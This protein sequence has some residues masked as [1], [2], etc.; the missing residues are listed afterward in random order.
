MDKNDLVDFLKLLAIL[1]SDEYKDDR[2]IA[3]KAMIEI[4]ENNP[5][6]IRDLDGNV[7]K[8]EDRTT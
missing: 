4:L 8:K 1:L 7:I 5:I 2:E 6:V 3:R